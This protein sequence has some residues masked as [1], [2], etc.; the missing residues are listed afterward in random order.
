MID[1]E[2]F[3]SHEVELWGAYILIFLMFGRNILEGRLSL[4]LIA[5]FFLE[6]RWCLVS[7]DSSSESQKLETLDKV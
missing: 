4:D 3:N 7:V 6:K 1:Y 2:M 5:F